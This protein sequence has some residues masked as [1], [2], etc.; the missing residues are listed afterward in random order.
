MS[1]AD[2]VEDASRAAMTSLGGETVTY[3][4]DGGVAVPVT[5][6][7]DAQYVLAEGGAGAG[8]EALGPAV[9]FQFADLPVDPE[10]DDPTLTIRGINYRVV[11]RRPDGLG[12]IVLEL[13]RV[14]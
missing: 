5:G 7:F 11:E 1:F 12:G 13:R 9:F 14:T 8:V 3:T 4:P 6:I 2:L 10:S